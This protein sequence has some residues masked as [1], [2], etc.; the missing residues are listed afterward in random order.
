MIAGADLRYVNQGK[1]V[2]TSAIVA[3]AQAE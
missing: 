3:N 1:D 2:G